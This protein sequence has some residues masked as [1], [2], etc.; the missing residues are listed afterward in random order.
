MSVKLV[1]CSKNPLEIM[2][3]AARTCYSESAPSK[4]GNKLPSEEKMV[5]LVRKVLGSGHWSIAEHVNFTFAIE[6]ISRACSHQL[7]RHR[8]ASF[9]QKSQRYVNAKN[10]QYV[11]PNSMKNFRANLNVKGHDVDLSYED[12][13]KLLSRF[14]EQAVDENIPK[15]DARFVLPNATITDLVMTLNLRELAHV[16]DMRA[17]G[18]AQWEIR[19]VAKEMKVELEIQ[20]PFLGEFL[21]IRC[22]KLGYCPDIE[23]CGR[24]PLRKI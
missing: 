14:Y 13:M 24:Y 12:L 22:E 2:Y 7:V 5:R 8:L 9:S 15:E 19:R 4:I 11:T 1:S 21:K 16:Y 23:T 6:G 18:R 3:T 20:F 10:F 17:C